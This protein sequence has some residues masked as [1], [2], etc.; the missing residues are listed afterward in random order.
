[1]LFISIWFAGPY[2]KNNSALAMQKKPYNKKK[3]EQRIGFRYIPAL[4]PELL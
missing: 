2:I 1:V 4:L 3:V